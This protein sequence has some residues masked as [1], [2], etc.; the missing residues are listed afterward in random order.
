MVSRSTSLV[1]DGKRLSLMLGCNMLLRERLSLSNKERFEW[2]QANDPFL[3]NELTRLF[4]RELFVRG[5]SKKVS[6]IVNVYFEQY[7]EMDY[8]ICSEDAPTKSGFKFVQSSRIGFL[9]LGKEWG[10][11][12]QTGKKWFRKPEFRFVW[13]KKQILSNFEEDYGGCCNV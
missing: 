5:E 9:R 11:N 1:R 13:L 8:F 7:P 3:L 4:G 12:R 10:R 6:S 2:L